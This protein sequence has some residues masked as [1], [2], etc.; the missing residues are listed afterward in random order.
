MDILLSDP[1]ILKKM[2]EIT[3]KEKERKANKNDGINNND[4]LNDNNKNNNNKTYSLKQ[5]K[6]QIK[7]QTDYI[8]DEDISMKVGN[9]LNKD[10]H[11]KNLK[12]LINDELNK[13]N[14]WK[15]RLETK[16][17][18]SKIKKCKSSEFHLSDKKSS[19]EIKKIEENKKDNLIIIEEGKN[20]ED[21]NNIIKENSDNKNNEI[22]ILENKNENFEKINLERENKKNENIKNEKSE[23]KINTNSQK[24]EENKLYEDKKIEVDEDI[25]KILNEKL[26]SLEN[27]INTNP[28]EEENIKEKIPEFSLENIPPKFQNSYLTIKDKINK[29][30]EAFNKYFYKDI[31]ESFYFKL[32][33]LVDE[34]YN[35]YIE[36]STTYHSQ[37]KE[38]EFL[39]EDE[40]NEEKQKDIQFTIDSL[41][42]EQQHEID[43]IEDYY[44]GVISDKINEFKVTSCKSN[45]GLEL[46]EEK[47]KLD[48]YTIINE[49]FYK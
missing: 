24:E 14:K 44:N 35:K 30:I 29:Y 4:N 49:I 41:K 48:I 20:E 26:K 46:M 15:L 13:Q 23:N 38:F 10:I 12:D 32:K 7:I 34:K 42:E 40:I 9:I 21:E 6:Q 19:D 8:K 37:I 28:P 36:I 27:L 47:L 39:L 11:N 31:F 18:N 2:V 43:R 22:Q 5:A 3:K 25:K 1:D 16:K 45:P 17:K 33:R